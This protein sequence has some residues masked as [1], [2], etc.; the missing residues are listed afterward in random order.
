VSAELITNIF[1]GT[2]T[3]LHDGAVV[4]SGNRI[5]KAAAY[6]TKLSDKKLPKKYGTRH[7]SAIG[8]AEA[9]NVISIV[10]SEETGAITVSHH[11]E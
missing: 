9:T 8:I 1:E 2:K 7:R 4:I 5:S 3:P 10:L 6:I 11:G